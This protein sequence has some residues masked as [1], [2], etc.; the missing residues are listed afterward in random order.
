MNHP[1]N[2]MRSETAILFGLV[3]SLAIVSRL[4]IYSFRHI[5]LTNVE[6][7]EEPLYALV[8]GVALALSVPTLP[9]V[10]LYLTVLFASA[11]APAE[12]DTGPKVALL[13]TALFL[14]G[15]V[16]AF[17]I[18][19][20]GVPSVISGAIYKGKVVVNAIGAV[21]I[22]LYGLKVFKESGLVGSEAL[23]FGLSRKAGPETEALILGFFAGLL[24]FHHLDPPYDSVFF[25]TGR[26][27][28]LSH[29]PVSV[30]SFGLGLS[31][32]YVAL[33]YG[34]GLLMNS[35]TGTKVLAWMK[36]IFGVLT[37]GLSVSFV[38]GV[39]K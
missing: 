36:G 29:H 4:F 30:I 19:I 7:G 32:M 8:G 37:L 22:A 5:P 14:V 21:L 3:L 18:T 35:W 27:N 26:G 34:F 31:A 15:F 24:L 23:P 6:G 38:F 12:L 11:R 13:P 9:L 1:K 39:F 10:V 25:L 28:P 16:S 17:I 2:I 20:G 33:G